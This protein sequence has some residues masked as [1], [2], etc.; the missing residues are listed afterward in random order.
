MVVFLFPYCW[1]LQPRQRIEAVKAHCRS[2]P[3]KLLRCRARRRL[4]FQNA[5]WVS[6][7]CLQAA[8]GS[9]QDPYEKTLL[10]YVERC[11]K[12]TEKHLGS[13]SGV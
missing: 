12:G 13:N 9:R 8:A 6:Q 3:T 10:Y 1:Q 2:N 11:V 7:F 4:F 5:P